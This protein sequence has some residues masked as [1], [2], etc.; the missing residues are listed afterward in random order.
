MNIRDEILSSVIKELVGPDENSKY[1]DETTGEEILL[2]SIHGSPKSRYGA[3]MLYPQQALNNETDYLGEE[4]EE[5][6]D[7]QGIN[8]DDTNDLIK[9]KRSNNGAGDG[10]LTANANRY[11][12]HVIVA[13]LM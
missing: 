7:E 9:S 13:N 11:Y 3:G 4:Q 2:A 6:N 8:E 5:I 10:S 12:R 1:N